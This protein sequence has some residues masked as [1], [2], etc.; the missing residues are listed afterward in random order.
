MTI[1]LILAVA[2]AAFCVWMTVRIVNRQEKWAKR[3]LVGTVV[4]LP[5]LYVASFGPACWISG[6]VLDEDKTEDNNETGVKA[7]TVSN[8]YEPIFRLAWRGHPMIC[9]PIYWYAGVGANENWAPAYGGD[10][11]YYWGR[12]QPLC[13]LRYLDDE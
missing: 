8:L 4:G 5:V 2:F 3:T 6:R 10:G 13:Q 7:E 1:L 9:R 12:F 11:H